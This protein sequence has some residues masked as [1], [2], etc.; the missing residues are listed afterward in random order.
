[1]KMPSIRSPRHAFGPIGFSLGS[2]GLLGLPSSAEREIHSKLRKQRFQKRLVWHNVDC[3]ISQ[4]AAMMLFRCFA[5]GFPNWL[6]P[7]LRKCEL[8]NTPRTSRI[9]GIFYRRLIGA[10]T[11]TRELSTLTRTR[12]IFVNDYLDH[13]LYYYKWCSRYTVA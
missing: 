10:T 11:M 13:S 1:M 9:V 12:C 5:R 6:R 4:S 2:F 7:E 8:I 3:D